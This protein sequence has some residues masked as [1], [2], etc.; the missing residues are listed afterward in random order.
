MLFQILQGHRPP[1]LVQRMGGIGHAAEFHLQ[2]RLAH[3][4]LRHQR[5][6]Q[7]VNRA[8][9]QQV[10]AA[11][12]H[13]LRQFHPG[14]GEALG[15]RRQQAQQIVVGKDHVDGQIHHR[16]DAPGQIARH[17][18]QQQGV[19]H[20]LARAPQQH[21]ARLGQPRLAATDR[22]HFHAQQVLQFLHRVAEGGLAFVQGLGG[23]GITAV[24]HHRMEGTPLIQGD[25]GGIHSIYS[26]LM[27]DL[28]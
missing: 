11:G 13:F 21:L 1:Q 12:Q 22:Q 16:L 15:K 3:K 28:F 19:F 6:H 10:M 23:L 2:Q 14:I 27:A 26:I 17:F 20:Q 8:G 18:F 5:R 4:A 9:Q 24:F 25:S 7:Q